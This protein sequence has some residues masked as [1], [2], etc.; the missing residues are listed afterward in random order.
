MN[1]TMTALVCAVALAACAS[2][3]YRNVSAANSSDAFEAFKKLPGSWVAETGTGQVQ[4]DYR[5]TSGGSAIEETLFSGTDHEMV[6]II[7][8]DGDGLVLTHYCSAGNQPRLRAVEAGAH[9]ADFAFADATNLKSLDDEHI[10]GA[11]FQF[12]DPDHFTAIWRGWKDGKEQEH[13]VLHFARKP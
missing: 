10:H 4:A 11:R 3:A 6:S 5:L 12:E 1:R 7:H 13:L 2:G 9:G 8:R